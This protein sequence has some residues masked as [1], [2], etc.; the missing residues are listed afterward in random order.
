MKKTK[1]ICTMGPN[2]NDRVLMK[3]LAENG[4][5]SCRTML[6]DKLK[7]IAESKTAGDVS[8]AGILSKQILKKNKSVLEQDLKYYELWHQAE[9]V[10]RQLAVVMRQLRETQTALKTISERMETCRSELVEMD[11]DLWKI[12]GLELSAV[13]LKGLQDGLKAN[14]EKKQTLENSAETLR[15]ER[16]LLNEQLAV[17]TEQIEALTESTEKKGDT[18]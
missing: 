11:S 12:P 2:T 3:K 7:Q 16:D 15:A 4:M 8:A 10:R 6:E 14:E 13:E 5:D 18:K 17:L 9:D 1:N